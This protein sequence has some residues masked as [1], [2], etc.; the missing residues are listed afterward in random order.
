[1]ATEFEGEIISADSRLFYRGMDIGTAKPTAAE[2]ALVPHHLINICLP[3]EP[4]TL[5]EYQQR[6]YE[7]INTVQTKGRI[8][9]LIGGTGQYVRAVVEGWSI[10]EV[11]PHPQLRHELL[12]QGGPELARWLQ[13]LDPATAGKLDPRNVRRV[14][15]ALEVTLIKGRPISE[16]QRKVPPPYR[17]KMIGLY[18][19]RDTLYRRIDSRVD[20]MMDDGLLEEVIALREAGYGS[21]LPA[22]SGLGYRQLGAYLHGEMG[23]E[24]S[25]ERIKFETHRFARQQANWFRQDDPNIAWFDAEEDEME[26]AVIKLVT[27]WLA[28]KKS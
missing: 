13:L 17:I 11:A 26:T 24:E 28:M 16:L 25:I 19:D 20:Q 18:R 23:L 5:A 7:I 3:D 27:K 15:R 1:L 4:L 6:A 14:I 22:M 2:Q 9:V 8:P 21:H 10:P 12:N